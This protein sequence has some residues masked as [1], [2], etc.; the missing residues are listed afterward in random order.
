MVDSC[1]SLTGVETPAT[2][3]GD[4]DDGPDRYRGKA[5]AALG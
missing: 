3:C 5:L 4:N 1:V 2:D